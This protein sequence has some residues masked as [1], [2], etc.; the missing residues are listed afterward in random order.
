MGP[1]WG[2]ILYMCL[3]SCLQGKGCSLL[4]LPALSTKGQIPTVTNQGREEKQKKK[5]KELL[6][7][8]NASMGQDPGFSSRNMLINVFEFF[9]RTTARAQ[10]EDDNSRQRRRFLK[11]CPSSSSTTN[12]K[13]ATDPSALTPNSAHKNC[14][15]KTMRQCQGSEREPPALLPLL[16]TLRV[17]FVWPPSVSPRMHTNPYSVP[18]PP[19]LLCLIVNP[20]RQTCVL[21][22][23]ARL[24]AEAAHSMQVSD[25][26]IIFSGK[27]NKRTLKYLPGVLL[28]AHL[29]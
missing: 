21:K 4:D 18:G 26:Q 1:S 22:V 13:K 3:V 19:L 8:N 27:I 25:E 29:H 24:P 7:N 17:W 28:F 20:R 12:Q 15:L 9:C 10:E 6:R 14:S 23:S 5:K 2:Q 16:R 11:H